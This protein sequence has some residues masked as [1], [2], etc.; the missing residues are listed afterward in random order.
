MALSP[1]GTELAVSGDDGTLRTI[2]VA[3]GKPDGNPFTDGRTTSLAFSGDGKLIAS[4]RSHGTIT[5]WDVATRTQVGDP[6]PGYGGSVNGVA[7]RPES[8]ELASANAD[9][10]VLLWDVVSRTRIELPRPGDMGPASSVAFTRDGTLLAA[11]G[12]EGVTIWD[13][14]TRV[15]VLTG[16]MGP[17][18]SVAFTLEGTT[19]AAGTRDGTVTLWDVAKAIQQGEPLGTRDPVDEDGFGPGAVYSVAFSPD[20]QTLATGGER[21]IALWNATTGHPSAQLL[22]PD[23]AAGGTVTE[24]V[25]TLAL[26]PDGMLLASIDAAGTLTLWDMSS[27]KQLGRTLLQAEAAPD[28]LFPARPLVFSPDGTQLAAA[29]FRDGSFAVW[30]VATASWEAR[31]CRLAN[32]NLTDGEWTRYF[33]DEPYRVTCP[34]LPPGVAAGGPARPEAAVGRR[35]PAP[36]IAAP[37]S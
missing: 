20:A 15:P 35:Q 10:T 22:A 29:D 31:S 6:L 27:R 26:S 4:G 7:F 9:G 2:D 13:M 3:S 16:R 21:G 8:T 14:A 11:G 34:D 25:A 17:V 24:Q 18:T 12:A 1:D 32:R 28:A 36:V 37:R 19:L 30:D 5:L 33:P 23:D